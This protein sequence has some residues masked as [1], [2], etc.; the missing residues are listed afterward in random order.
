MAETSLVRKLN[1]NVA[2]QC[3]AWALLWMVYDAVAAETTRPEPLWRRPEARACASCY[4]KGSH[5]G[6]A[7]TVARVLSA[8][9]AAAASMCRRTHL[10]CLPGWRY[11]HGCLA[12][13]ACSGRRVWSHVRAG[14]GAREFTWH[15]LPRDDDSGSRDRDSQIVVCVACFYHYLG[16]ADL[17]SALA[18]VAE[19]P[20][21][22]PSYFRCSGASDGG[23][24][25]E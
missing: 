1:F 16:I 20:G 22:S 8:R 4:E 24:C 13:L 17:P 19:A 11:D 3:C 9:V 7:Y 10:H 5:V 23:A 12:A 15:A 21:R 14:V 25:G 6:L 18:L 2:A